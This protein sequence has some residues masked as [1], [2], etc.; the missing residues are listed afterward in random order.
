MYQEFAAGARTSAR[1]SHQSSA[2]K[3]TSE[4]AKKIGPPWWWMAELIICGPMWTQSRPMV[5]MR[6]PFRSRASGTTI[7]AKRIR[8]HEACRNNLP[9]TSW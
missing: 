3:G 7:T 5:R 1:R 6:N 4:R 9:A 8:R 2:P